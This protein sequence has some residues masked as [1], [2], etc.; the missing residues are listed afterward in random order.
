M[1]PDF[2][3][4]GYLPQGIHK[5]PMA[6]FVDRFCRGSDSRRR[7]Y[8]NFN[9]LLRQNREINDKIV[10]LLIDGSFV[11][12]KTE[13]GDLDIILVFARD[14]DFDSPS[15]LR[16]QNTKA[17][18]NIHLIAILEDMPDEFEYWIDFFGHDRG[19]EPKGLVEVLR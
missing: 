1:I 6:E 16:L 7:L 19:Q 8:A 3:A 11:T 13:P 10:R 17:D 15:S 2:N 5:A 12:S 9:D 4:Q 14:F 18:Y